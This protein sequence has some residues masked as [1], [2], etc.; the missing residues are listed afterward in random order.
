MNLKHVALLTCLALIVCTGSLRADNTAYATTESGDFGTIDLN[1]GAF[2]LLGNSGLTL[3]G[4]GVSG[5]NLYGVT[6]T[7]AAGTLFQINPAN[8]AL[9]TIGSSGVDYYD[10]GST[11]TGL[12]ALTEVSGNTDLYSINPTTG[13]AT[14]IGATGVAAVGISNLSSNSSTLYFASGASLYTINTTTG[15]GTLVGT[16]GDVEMGALVTETGTLYGG[17]D[18]PGPPFAVDTINTTTG[19]ATTGPTV[20]GLPSGDYFFG[21]APAATVPEPCT[22]LLLSCALGGCGLLRRRNAAQV[23][24]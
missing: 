21:L 9:T 3:S 15:V 14:L 2:T 7:S 11:L 13:A 8:G 16:M 19:A 20:T 1:T 22:L 23:I 10:F 5:G 24:R 4:L 17:Q 6:Y 18:F 12:Y